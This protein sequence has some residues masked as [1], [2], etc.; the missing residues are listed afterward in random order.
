MNERMS[1]EEPKIAIIYLL[2]YHNQS[3]IDDMVSALKRMTYPKDKVELVIVSNPHPVEGSFVRYL[4]ET[5]VP[6][7]GKEIP[8]VT[9][10]AQ[11]EN[12]GFAGGNNVGTVWA[13]EN[14]FDYVYYH[15][16][17]GFFAGNVLEPLVK[18]F[19]EDTKV[20]I[21]QSLVMLYPET[22]LINSAGNSF[23]YLGFGFCHGYRKKIQDLDLPVVK[24]IDYATGAAM[25]IKVDL[26]KKFG[27]WDPDFFMYHE[28]LEWSLRLRIA[29]YKIKLMRDSVFY[30]KY[31][32][33]RSIDKFFFMER[34]RHAV[35]LMFFRWPTLLLLLPIGIL[36]ELGL[37][38]FSIK[39]GYFN[40]RIEVYKYWLNWKNWQIW[41]KKRKYIQS[42]RQVKDRHLLK[43][44]VSGINFQEKEVESPLVKYVGNPI[45]AI[46]YWL[47]V[48][49]LIWW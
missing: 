38:F 41:L 10:L 19:F 7:S 9:I 6:L 15:N 21:A 47:V 14:G 31:Q 35:M 33:G 45:M 5:V 44:T 43:H 46:Y 29:G 36:L 2:Y 4:E 17:D 34:N 3:Y 8:H 37:W 40:K 32:F 18:V 27:M 28:D 22:E 49:S 16:N 20:G 25:M 48:K 13:I 42:I 12:L 1:I 11:T 30:H 26:I 23:Q 39:N 24:E